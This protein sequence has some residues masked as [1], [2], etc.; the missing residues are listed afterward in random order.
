MS[1]ALRRSVTPNACPRMTRQRSWEE[2]CRKSTNGS[3]IVPLRSRHNLTELLRG[4]PRRC[5]SLISTDI[6]ATQAWRDTLGEDLPA[7]VPTNTRYW[8]RAVDAVASR[9]MTELV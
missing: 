3:A 1:R 8:R 7:G 5:P 4:Q 2:R 6:S 9:V